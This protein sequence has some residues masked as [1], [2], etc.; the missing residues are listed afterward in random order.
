[1]LQIILNNETK[2]Q[3]LTVLFLIQTPLRLIDKLN[4]S[5]T[6]INSWIWK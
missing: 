5:G 1:M 4:Q 3:R 2:A 6:V